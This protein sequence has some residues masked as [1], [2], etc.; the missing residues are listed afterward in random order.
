[1][2]VNAKRYAR[3]V[4]LI[5]VMLLAVVL[6]MVALASREI[7]TSTR[8][9]V[10]A[11]AQSRQSL[12]VS[13]TARGIES[14]Y[15]SIINN[16][17]LL[18]R[19]ENEDAAAPATL[20]SP[21]ASADAKQTFTDRSVAAAARGALVGPIL[22]KQLQ[23]R[24]SLLMSID[25]AQL[26][27]PSP[28]VRVI[29]AEESAP[30]A[31]Q[32][33]TEARQWLETVE[34]PSI[35]GLKH[36]NDVGVNLVCVP[37]PHILEPAPRDEVSRGARPGPPRAQQL[38]RDEGPRGS[39]PGGPSAPQPP[40]DS[41]RMLIAVVPIREMETRFL[42]ILNEDA[43]TGAWLI[44]ERM[45]AMAA[46]RPQLV[47]VNMSEITD[48]QIRAVTLNYVQH[49]RAVT[50]LV[51]K[52]FNLGGASFVPSLVS[53]EPIHIGDKTWELFFA[54]SMAQIEGVVSRLF[55][56]ALYWAVFVVVSVTAILVSTA[57]QMIRGRVRLERVRHD[58]LSREITQ[59]REI[60]LAWLPDQPPP[61]HSLDIAAINS[62]ASHISGDFYNWFDLPDGRLV[63]TIGDVTGHG[64]AA[65]FLM[66]TTQLL[67]RNTMTRLGDPGSC[68][69]EV[70]RQLCVQVFNGQF[71]TMLIMVMDVASGSLEIATA[72][73]PAPLLGDGESFQ[74]LPL[75][76]Q[77][78]LGVER[79]THYTT[80][81][82]QLPA[83]SSLLLYTDGVVE[84]L[85]AQNA[86]FGAD[87]LQ[88]TL[89]GRYD[90]AQSMLDRVVAAVDTFRGELELEDDL[91][92]VAI[93]LQATP[94]TLVK[95][96]A[97]V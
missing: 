20:P 7:F 8:D 63:V 76:P 26:A 28:A 19:A 48:P 52:S 74:P 42:K 66:A 59:A 5:H 9:E 39:R 60:Q 78:V 69:T 64:M 88:R 80:E 34:R 11:Q 31:E 85:G 62:P 24:V 4:L 54:T 58:L 89:Y 87:G 96:V 47:G 45:T 27:R 79:S 37:F 38:A 15:Q 91:T 61:A 12:L 49:G 73:H 3:R 90:N 13:Q 16:L 75:E 72:G 68:L 17:D 10:I 86:R 25:R 83:Q 2:E 23:G 57:V 50:K 35:S 33:I 36:F 30:P 92:L 18:R 67:V 94:A 82:F 40:R 95:V 70:N 84:C 71:V 22:W 43:N 51:D 21:P 65:A 6:A 53:G 93:Q 14:H 77:L 32:V 97:E 1:M 55:H 56:R 29:G 41:F 46:S 44:D 81:K